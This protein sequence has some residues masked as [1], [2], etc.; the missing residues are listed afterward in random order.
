[1]ENENNLA[2]PKGNLKLIAV[3]FVIIIIG[4]ICMI[5]GGGEGT[6]FNPEIYNAQ[7]ITVGPLISVFGF[8]FEIYAI[9]RKPK[10]DKTTDLVIKNSDTVVADDK[11]TDSRLD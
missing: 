6:S 2:L 10:A 5:G 1:M 8:F 3:G 9:L 11:K 7:R 4:F